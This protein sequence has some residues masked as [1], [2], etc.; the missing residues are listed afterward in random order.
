MVGDPKACRE[1]ASRCAELAHDAKT[2]EL[3][4]ILIDL[5]KNWLKLAIELEQAAA[6]LSENPPPARKT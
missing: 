6:L 1:H 5:S 2:P 3:K 4:L